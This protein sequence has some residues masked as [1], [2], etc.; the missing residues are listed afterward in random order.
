MAVPNL[1]DSIGFL[2][3]TFPPLASNKQ[4]NKDSETPVC[5]K[6]TQVTLRNYFQAFF[7]TSKTVISVRTSDKIYPYPTTMIDE[8]NLDISIF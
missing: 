6:K 1:K 7:R 3:T 4:A 5:L 8:T 2:P